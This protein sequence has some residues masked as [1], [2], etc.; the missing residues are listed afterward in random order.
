MPEPIGDGAA[1]LK[2][3]QRVKAL[4]Q[5]RAIASAL[6]APSPTILHSELNKDRTAGEDGR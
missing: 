2:E 3:L 4:F 1:V 5:A 6:G